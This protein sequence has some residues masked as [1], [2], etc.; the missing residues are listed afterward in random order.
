MTPMPGYKIY[1]SYPDDS[2]SEWVN[3]RT[4][5]IKVCLDLGLPDVVLTLIYSGLDIIGWLD[6]PEGQQYAKESSF[7]AWSER[8][9]SPALHA[10]DGEQVNR[11]VLCSMWN[12]SHWEEAQVCRKPGP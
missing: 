9:V 7:L 6:A 1:L 11:P 3:A 2:V 12:P 5:A 8:Y 10:I 4:R